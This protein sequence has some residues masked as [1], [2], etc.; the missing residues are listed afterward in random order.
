[1]GFLKL[2]KSIGVLIAYSPFLVAL[3]P[4]EPKL[5]EFNTLVIV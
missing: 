4:K 5:A 1:M 2:I 3:G